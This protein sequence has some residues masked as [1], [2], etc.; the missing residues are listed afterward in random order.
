MNAIIIAAGS[1]KRIGGESSKIPKSMILVN[2]KPIIEYQISVLKKFNIKKIIVITGPYNEK[3]SISGVDFVQDHR[4]QEHDILGSLMEARKFLENE[5]LVLYSD[6]LFEEEIINQILQSKA[7]IGVG[8]DMNWEKSYIGRTEHTKIEAENVELNSKEEIINFRKNIQSDT[9][10]I[11]EFIGIVKF[12]TYGIERFVKKFEY[13]K[14]THKGSFKQAPSLSKAYL[15]DM[16][17]ELI[18]S[19]IIVNPIFISGKWCEIDTI[20]D[21]KNAEKIFN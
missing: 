5:L 20:Q 17:Q 2:K 7:D 12:S 1:G 9:S 6:I 11:G 18:D 16:F 3:F 21:L 14:E 13:L 8:I 4:Y 15:T 19:K 10:K